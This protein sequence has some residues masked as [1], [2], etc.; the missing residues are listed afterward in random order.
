MDLVFRNDEGP[1]RGDGRARADVPA[2]AQ[3]ATRIGSADRTILR[4]LRDR[5]RDG[6]PSEVVLRD[7]SRVLIFNISWGYEIAWDFEVSRGYAPVAAA[8]QITTN[9]SP[10]IGGVP[11]EVFTTAAVVAVNDPETG[12]PLLAVG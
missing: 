10:S 8:A 4:L 11:V 1:A 12:T 2:S 7:G 5:D 6:M 3:S 9:I